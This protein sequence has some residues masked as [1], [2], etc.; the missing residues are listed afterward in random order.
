MFKSLILLSAAALTWAQEREHKFP[1]ELEETTKSSLEPTQRVT[2]DGRGSGGFGGGVINYAAL[3]G[4]PFENGNIQGV[5]PLQ[6]YEIIRDGRAVPL[7]GYGGGY[8]GL[9]GIVPA[10][11][12]QNELN[13]AQAAGLSREGR[14]IGGLGGLGFIGGGSPGIGFIGGAGAGGADFLGGG[15]FAG[16]GFIG[17][18]GAGAGLIG[19]GAGGIG[20]IGG[21][22]GAGLISGGAGAGLINGGGAGFV[23]PIGG[24]G[25]GAGFIGARGIRAPGVYQGLVGLVGNGAGQSGFG[26]VAGGQGIAQ[27][28]AGGLGGG[29]ERGSGIGV[30]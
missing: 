4:N 28:G 11:P 2:R 9:Y 8:T 5:V 17:G 6:G 27:L 12:F 20:L 21:G 14:Q 25:G 30:F 1:F 7:D 13:Q 3:N 15:G 19:G 26:G 18:G 10:D 16:P 29:A 24:L 23:G 22:G